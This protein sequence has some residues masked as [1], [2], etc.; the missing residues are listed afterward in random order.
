MKKQIGL[1]LPLLLLFLGIAGGDLR[2]SA[3]GA[4]E[5]KAILV[6]SFGT[7]YPDTRK[8]TIESVENKVRAAF[9]DYEVRR[10]F[11]S[12]IIIKKLLERD[13]MK[14]ETEKEA[15]MRLKAEGYTEVIVQPLHIEA[16]AE[17][18][19]V[20]G[21][22][23]HLQAEKAF[24]RLELGRPLLYYPGVEGY[25][26]DYS[27]A[28]KALESQMPQLGRR[29]AVV[30]MGHGGPHPANAAYATLQ[31]KLEANGLEKVFV[32]TVEGYPDLDWVVEK[33]KETK[34]KKVTLMPFMMVAGDHANNDMAGDEEDS[35]KSILKAAGFEVNTVVKGLGE[36]PAIQ[37]IYVQHIKDAMQPKEKKE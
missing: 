19:K 8:A 12:R 24:K 25:P 3:A 30:F 5:K 31:M 4:S 1:I 6:V 32:Y 11:T 36:N 7:T 23:S 14:V 26:D 15:L 28:I 17:Y 16:G 34:R 29:D 33:L 27:I 2:A 18:E 21:I 35:A 9:P 22:V 20:K 10:A 13:N 37:D